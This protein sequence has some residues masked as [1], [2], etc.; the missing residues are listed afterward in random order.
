VDIGWLKDFVTLAELGNFSRAAEARHVTQPAFSRRIRSLESWVGVDLFQRGPQGVSLTAAGQQFRQGADELL[1]RVEQLREEAREAAGKSVAALRFAATHALS[2]SFFPHWVRE[3]GS[4]PP[5]GPVELISDSMEACENIMLRGQA[6]FLLCHYHPEAE[7]R[8]DPGLFTSIAVGREKLVPVVAPDGN[9]RPA[10]TLPGTKAKPVAY[11][12]YRAESGLGRI[13]AARRAADP[14]PVFLDTVFTTHLA[15]VLLS[16]AR[17][18]QGVGWVPLALAAPD[19]AAGKLVRAG[20][21]NF[22]VDVE[23]RLFRPRGELNRVAEQF[24]NRLVAS[25]KSQAN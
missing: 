5:A 3:A 20:D 21:A 6:H 10:W 23:I 4:N 9:G 17:D 19:I 24:W 2:F 16:M 15:A 11:L 1:R 13:L 8:F 22:D 7:S 25:Q 14:R 12:G 18:G